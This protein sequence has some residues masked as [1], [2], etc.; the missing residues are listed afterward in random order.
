MGEGSEE[1][2]DCEHSVADMRSIEVEG[3]GATS[4]LGT[5]LASVVSADV[6]WMSDVREVSTVELR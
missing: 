5:V 3:S 2:G 4:S 6:V 1:G